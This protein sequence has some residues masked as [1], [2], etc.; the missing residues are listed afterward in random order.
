LKEKSS[1]FSRWTTEDDGSLNIKMFSDY[2]SLKTL[3]FHEV[4]SQNYDMVIQCAAISD[5]SVVGID[6]D[7]KSVLGVQKISNSENLVLKL[8]RNE[9]LI[10]SVK[11]LSKNKNL[12]L[13]G[14]KL[15]S[16]AT[17]NEVQKKVMSLFKKSHCDYVVHNDTTRIDKSL[18]LHPFSIYH[19]GNSGQLEETECHNLN[20]LC[21]QISETLT[22]QEML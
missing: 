14:F 18:D 2:E 13:I 5:Y 9:K 17:D 20:E 15:T 19:L 6:A 8:K 7:E 12:K 16:Q 4:Q 22:L 10:D 1:F 11:S 21:F 3:L